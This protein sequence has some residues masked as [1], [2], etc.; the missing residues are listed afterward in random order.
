MAQ[1]ILLSS[2]DLCGEWHVDAVRKAIES[3]YI[4][5][6]NIYEKQEVINPIT[7][8]SEFNEILVHENKQCRVSFSNITVTGDNDAATQ[9]QIVK[10]FIAPEINIKAGSK[11][12]ITHLGNTIDYKRSGVPAIYS[13]HQEIVLDLFDRYA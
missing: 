11:I 7:H 4:D 5:S 1:M 13:T 10:L 9:T 2:E 3:T 8:V 12:A 6:C